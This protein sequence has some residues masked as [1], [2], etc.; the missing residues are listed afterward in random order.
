MRARDVGLGARRRAGSRTRRGA[1]AWGRAS[2]LVHD[3]ASAASS[4]TRLVACAAQSAAR[5]RRRDPLVCGRSDARNPA[6]P[7]DCSVARERRRGRGR[8]ALDCS[9]RL[10][11]DDCQEGA[12]RIE[13]LPN[14]AP[15]RIQHGRTEHVLTEGSRRVLEGALRSGRATRS[16]RLGHQARRRDLLQHVPVLGFD[17]SKHGA[18]MS[19]PRFQGN[20]PPLQVARLYEVQ[21]GRQ[22]ASERRAQL[23]EISGQAP[24]EARRSQDR[25]AASPMTARAD[26]LA[27]QP[28][29]AALR[30]PP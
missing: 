19:R 4:S 28:R 12:R 18:S 27:A 14:A 25:H 22:R 10:L 16:E 15:I 30:S 2:R 7:G 3:L 23:R 17:D 24:R 6:K 21:A 8:P 26:R 29:S 1:C 5:L 11:C 20:L 9:R 13:A